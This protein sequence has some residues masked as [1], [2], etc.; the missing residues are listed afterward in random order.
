MIFFYIVLLLITNSLTLAAKEFKDQLSDA[1]IERTSHVVIYDGSYHKID[2]PGGDV[3]A[4]Y[5]VC[6]DVVIR[7]YRKLGIDLQKEVHEDRKAY[8]SK[9]PDN[10]GLKTPDKNIDHRRVPNLQAFFAR[11]G[12]TLQKSNNPDDYILSDIITWRLPNNLPHIGIVVDDLS[13]DGKRPMIVHNIAFGPKMN[14]ILFKYTITG[15]YHFYGTS[16]N[17]NP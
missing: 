11:K 16:E 8:F 9:Y 6:T 12:E 10:W 4:R 3:P 14:D 17:Y 2:Y 1:A 7:S 15:H 5:G 13:V